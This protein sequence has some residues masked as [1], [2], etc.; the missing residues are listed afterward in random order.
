MDPFW[1]S[2]MCSNKPARGG[3]LCVGTFSPFQVATFKVKEIDGIYFASWT[4]MGFFHGKTRPTEGW[5]MSSVRD[6]LERPLPKPGWNPPQKDP[7]R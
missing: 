4:G 6:D 7:N 1:L 2:L 5:M 3:V